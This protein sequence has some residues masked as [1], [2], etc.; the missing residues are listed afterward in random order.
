M[1]DDDTR[2]FCSARRCSQ[3]DNLK[4]HLERDEVTAERLC[5][6]AGD[7]H[8]YTDK[9]ESTQPKR[10][11]TTRAQKRAIWFR[12]PMYVL[13][14]SGSCRSLRLARR[15]PGGASYRGKSG[16]AASC[17]VRRGQ[18]GESECG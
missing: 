10:N 6:Q 13:S 3:V 16:L 11:T 17:A 1:V 7:Y 8:T 15:L 4:D 2:L 9:S 18:H 14:G 5:K 12:Q